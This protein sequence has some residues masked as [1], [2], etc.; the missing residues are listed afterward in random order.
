MSFITC[1]SR[2]YCSSINE[3]TYI[4]IFGYFG[5]FFVSFNVEYDGFVA[6]LD[7]INPI[8]NFIFILEKVPGKTFTRNSFQI[9]Q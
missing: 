3:L 8:I 9:L 1:Y 5:V 4:N 2:L 7:L 6:L